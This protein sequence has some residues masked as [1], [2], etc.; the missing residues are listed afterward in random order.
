[1]GGYHGIQDYLST[2]KIENTN[3]PLFLDS[4]KT[5]IDKVTNIVKGLNQF[6]RDNKVL[7]EACDIHSIIDNCLTMLHNQQKNK[8][9]IDKKY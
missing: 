2:T 8:I 4:I 3:V 6:S 1:M 7:N 5:G 9:K